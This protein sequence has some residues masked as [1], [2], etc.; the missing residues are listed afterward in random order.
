MPSTPVSG[1]NV[2][3]DC[4]LFDGAVVRDEYN[5]SESD[6]YVQIT[7]YGEQAQQLLDWVLKDKNDSNQTFSF[8]EYSLM[9]EE[10]IRVYTNEVHLSWGGFSFKRGSPIWNNSDADVAVLLDALTIIVSE[11]SYDPDSPPGCGE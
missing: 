8:P 7:N 6:E 10:S 3:I 4:V 1:L 5:T 2:Q 11:K 9:P